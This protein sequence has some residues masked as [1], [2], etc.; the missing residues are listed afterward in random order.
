MF[1]KILVP[2]DG[3]ELARHAVPYAAA[4][5]RVR[6]GTLFLTY[7]QAP[8]ELPTDAP[9]QLHATGT[10]LRK[11]GVTVSIRIHPLS[12]GSPGRVLLDT[13]RE[14][15]AGIIVM[16]TRARG[17][18][19]RTLLGS[20]ADY[21]LRHTKIPVLFCTVHTD[22]AWTGKGPRRILLPL[23]GS[24]VAEEAI[25]HARALASELGATMILL[26]VIDPGTAPASGN[27]ESEVP[28]LDEL[29]QQTRAYLDRVVTNLAKDGIAAEI[30]VR[31]GVPDEAIAEVARV[32]NVELVVMATHG[33]GGAVRL[34][35]GSVAL[36][37]LQ[38][39]HVPVLLVRTGGGAA[40]A[41]GVEEAHVEEPATRLTL[42][43]DQ[44]LLVR[45]G[46]MLL[47]AEPG[48]ATHAVDLLLA[49]LPPSE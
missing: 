6:G 49:Q 13:A 9:T 22:N 5:A 30:Q 1:T 21:V 26:G 33:R 40:H 31:V 3:S 35:L 36:H 24:A 32:Q 2:F 17:A 15:E 45:R 28:F 37:T 25:P 38:R 48:Y 43:S 8:W 14:I 20:V 10:Q 11:E 27:P 34:L 41:S 23:D 44:L 39:S 42:T 19:G 46:L 7:V 29:H 18:V 16:G 47:R 4:L 12:V